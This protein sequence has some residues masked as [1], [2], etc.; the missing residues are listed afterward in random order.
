MIKDLKLYLENITALYAKTEKKIKLKAF[1]FTLIIGL[2]IMT[3]LLLVFLNL[4]FQFGGVKN[5]IFGIIIIISLLLHLFL[6]IIFPIYYIALE[7]LTID[8]EEKISFKKMFLAYLLDFISLIFLI[9][10]SIVICVFVN[11]TI[12]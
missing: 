2:F 7:T 4:F 11:Y 9:I 1:L 6:A 10:V 12:Y 5:I 3:P 8:V